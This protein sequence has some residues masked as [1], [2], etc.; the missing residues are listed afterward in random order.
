MMGVPCV[1]ALRASRLRVLNPGVLALPRLIFGAQ[2]VA[3]GLLP[4]LGIDG[5][6]A[7]PGTLGCE[8]SHLPY[9]PN[10]R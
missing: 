3:L 9:P 10:P 8:I 2:S 6:L 7:H 1:P 4:S 5:H